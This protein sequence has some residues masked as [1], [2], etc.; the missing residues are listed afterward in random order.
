M[1]SPQHFASLFC[2][3]E[4]REIFDR[5]NSHF[6]ILSIAWA[7]TLD[8]GDCKTNFLFA[9][10]SILNAEHKMVGELMISFNDSQWL[11]RNGFLLWWSQGCK[12]LRM[13]HLTFDFKQPKNQQARRG[14]Q[15]QKTTLDSF[16]GR[17]GTCSVNSDRTTLIKAGIHHRMGVLPYKPNW[18]F[19]FTSFLWVS[20][21]GIH[22][23]PNGI[24]DWYYFV[25]SQ[26]QLPSM[27]VDDATL[28]KLSS[29][30]SGCDGQYI[31]PMR[32]NENNLTFPEC[33]FDRMTWGLC[34]KGMT[35]SAISWPWYY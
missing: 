19:L 15:Q 6:V 18:H 28:S 2:S 30:N 11:T 9:F 31:P 20:L 8:T 3:T 25:W 32:C 4:W 7:S 35:Q 26:F 14:S 21:S 12:Y 23:I 29:S 13:V 33:K 5:G 34:A 1:H 10:S 24:W 27:G 16:E 22:V 17:H